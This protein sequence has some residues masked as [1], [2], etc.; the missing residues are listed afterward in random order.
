[1]GGVLASLPGLL[2]DTRL[3]TAVI[4]LRVERRDDGWVLAG[5]DSDDVRLVNDY[6]GYLADRH[7]SPGT[8]RAYAFDLLALLRWLAGQDRRLDEV[9]TE[10]LLRF[11]AAC[12][13]RALRAARRT[14]RRS[15]GRCAGGVGGGDDEPA[16]G[17]GQR[18]VRVPR[19]ARPDRAE[20]DA[21]GAR[22]AAAGGAGAAG[23]AAGA[24]GPAAAAVG[25][26]G[27]RAAA[28]A[29]R[30]GPGGGIRAAGEPAHL[31]GPGDRRADA[32]LRAA[33]GRGAGA[34]GAPMWTSPGAGCG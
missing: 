22:R 15:G 26:A 21:D 19:D 16:A 29:P 20:P 18:A 30:P 13:R 14:W 31:A 34:G 27:A 23:R 9:D 25:A 2:V 11:L 28:A 4:E 12:R 3:M 24:S 8:R 6:L 5:A 10:V 7:Y 32:V 33:L 17:R 1:M